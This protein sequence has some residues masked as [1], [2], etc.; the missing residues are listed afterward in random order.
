M[1]SIRTK[2]TLSMLVTSLATALVVGLVARVI[3]QQ[4]FGEIAIDQ[5]FDAFQ[6]HVTAFVEAYG[7]IEAGLEVEPFPLFVSRLTAE[8]AG[9]RGQGPPP[10]MGGPGGPPAGS[11]IFAL[12]AADGSEVLL[13]QL[14]YETLGD[15]EARLLPMARPVIVDGRVLGNAVPVGAPDVSAFDAG[16]LDA[17]RAAV[18]WGVFVAALFAVVVGFV[19]S[20][21]LSRSVRRLSLAI[22]AVA[23][24]HFG[25]RVDVASRDEIGALA[26][27]FNQMSAELRASHERIR[28]QADLLKELSLRDELTGLHNRRHFDEQAPR[29]FAQARCYTQPLA[30]AMCD[31]DRFKQINDRFSHSTDD[32]V[33]RRLAGILGPG[34][35]AADLLARYGGEEFAILFPQSGAEAV[36][37]LCERLRAEVEAHPWDALAEGLRVTI[38]IGVDGDT[39]RGSVEAMLAAADARMYEAKA[40]GRNRVV[41]G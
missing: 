31:I 1:P 4:R 7:S 8:G 6:E 21:R 27:A 3:V 19:F 12:V 20:E 24:G 18:A 30:V 23:R 41:T 34:V 13:G 33:L 26:G 38:S 2:L 29:L 17:T 32:M 10:G 40:S 36:A 39:G 5:A 22:D 14:E 37:R 16:Y 9:A 35:R 11:V 15:I 25:H 28:S